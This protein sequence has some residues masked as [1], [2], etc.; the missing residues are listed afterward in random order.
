[1]QECLYLR[2][3]C[4][5]AFSEQKFERQICA[6]GLV[7]EVRVGSREPK[8]V[9]PYHMRGNFSSYE[10]LEHELVGFWT[11]RCILPPSQCQCKEPRLISPYPIRHPLSEARSTGCV[12]CISLQN[13]GKRGNLF[14]LHTYA[15]SQ[16]PEQSKKLRKCR[17]A[18][19]SL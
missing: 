16:P 8:G 6:G 19:N 9:F 2:L 1:M 18:A 12:T 7:L 10:A 17:L 3:T 5:P 15:A 14:L 4:S 11:G 13:K